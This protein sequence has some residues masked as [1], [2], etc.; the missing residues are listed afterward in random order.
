MF[1]TGWSLGWKRWNSGILSFSNVMSHSILSQSFE[2]VSLAAYQH[3]PVL[4]W[5][6]YWE[7]QR[8]N[9]FRCETRVESI[10]AEA[11]L[12]RFTSFLRTPENLFLSHSSERALKWYREQLYSTLDA[13]LAPLFWF[14]LFHPTHPGNPGSGGTWP[15]PFLHEDPGPSPWWDEVDAKGLFRACLK[16]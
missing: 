9:S 14:E 4:R 7:W 1:I 13:Q 12:L 5:S 11:I 3:F 8:S 16:T 10:N 2:S 15:H 6:D